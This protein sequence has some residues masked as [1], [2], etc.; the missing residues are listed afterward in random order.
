MPRTVQVRLFVGGTEFVTSRETLTRISSFF[1]G[2]MDT[3]NDNEP[4]DT[5]CSV[6]RDPTHFRHVLNYLRGSFTCPPTEREARELMMEADF[7]ALPELVAELR[8]EARRVRAES[9]AF[10]IGIIASKMG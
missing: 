8:S 7:Y 5:S 2:L 6:D 10:Q 3:S 1:S 9:V 4:E